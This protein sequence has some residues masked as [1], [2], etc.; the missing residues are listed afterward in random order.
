MMKS[1]PTTAALLSL[2]LISGSM[3]QSDAALSDADITA[4]EEK[5]AVSAASDEN[6]MLKEKMLLQQSTIQALTESLAGANNE[7]EAYKREAA[8][9]R[10]KIETLGLIESDKS[11]VKLQER[12]LAAVSDLR[13]AQHSQQEMQDHLVKLSESIVALLKSS[14][15]VDPQLRAV[16]ETELRSSNDMLGASPSNVVAGR[17]DPASLMEGMIIDVKDDLS[18]IIANIGKRQDVKVGMPFQV[19]RNN[20]LIGEVRVVDV[21]DRICG[22]VVQNL[23]SLNQRIQVGDQIKVDARQ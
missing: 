2:V 11:G 4:K 7:A 16:V 6:S 20:R 21:R 19:T 10:M 23:A 1:T 22:A 3:F 14:E 9:L 5:I 12:L 8:D 17:A 13:L 15:N 18:L